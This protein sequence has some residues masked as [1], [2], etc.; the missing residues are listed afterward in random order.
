LWRLR[1]P[2]RANPCPEEERDVPSGSAGFSR[3]GYGFQQHP[4]RPGESA[5]SHLHP[6]SAGESLKCRAA[7]HCCRAAGFGVFFFFLSP[8]SFL[9]PEGTCLLWI[10]FVSSE[11]EMLAAR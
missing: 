6:E 8:F 10:L 7:K 4:P 5:D 1:A 9:G 2:L 3:H 11:N